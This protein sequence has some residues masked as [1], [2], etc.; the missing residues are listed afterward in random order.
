ML[1]KS[2]A[3]LTLAL[4]FVLGAVFMIIFM[5]TL[6][7]PDFLGIAAWLGVLFGFAGLAVVMILQVLGLRRLGSLIMLITGI[8]VTVFVVMNLIHVMGQDIP[9]GGNP[10]SDALRELAISVRRA[11][12]TVPGFIYLFT[13]GI[14]PI[15]LGLQGFL[16]KDKK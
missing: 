13:L 12:Q 8:V 4:V 15:V 6:D 11:T 10:I 7:D 3:K 1:K 5:S 9:A 14:T 16:S 2:W